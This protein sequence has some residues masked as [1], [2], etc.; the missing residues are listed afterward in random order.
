MTENIYK[1]IKLIAASVILV[2]SIACDS[3][4]GPAVVQPSEPT[5][6][7]A[8]VGNGRIE[9]SFKTTP[10][11]PISEVRISWGDAASS[12][13]IIIDMSDVSDGVVTKM[14]DNLAEGD[15]NFEVRA[16]FA[17]GTP[18][19]PARITAHAYGA[20]YAAALAGCAITGY[21]ATNIGKNIM[22]NIDVPTGKGFEGFSI[23]Y[24]DRSGAEKEINLEK[25][26]GNLEL[27]NVDY[28]EDITYYS[29]FRPESDAL[30]TFRSK[31]VKLSLD[32]EKLTL[33]RLSASAVRMMTYNVRIFCG[34]AH[35]N[36]GKTVESVPAVRDR[37][38]EIINWTNPDFVA[39]QEVDLNTVRSGRDDQVARLAEGTG[40]YGTFVDA[41]DRSK[42]KYG[43]GLLSRKKPLNVQRV[44]LPGT[45]ERRV[46]MIVEFSDCYVVNAH[47]SLTPADRVTSANMLIDKC[48]DISKPIL[49][50]GDLNDTPNSSAISLLKQKYTRLTSDIFTHPAD[51]P[52]WCLDYIFGANLSKGASGI[53]RMILLDEKEASDHRPWVVDIEL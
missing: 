2:A 25:P 24:V 5:G 36:S 50:A 9:L 49:I 47:F 31:V 38:I 48:K 33:P 20:G 30:D 41:I 35:E 26:E 51:V 8:R 27:Q 37:L 46:M 17:D 16:Y 14:I 32:P 28:G 1:T 34:M 7:D 29:T 45:E 12:E 53:K 40:M 44:Q 18:S 11:E 21:E 42:G 6:L 52:L 19:E 23:A 3:P 4:V 39:L 10:G 13:T 22:L 15:H 43:I